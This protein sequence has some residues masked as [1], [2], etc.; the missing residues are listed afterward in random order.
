MKLWLLLCL[1]LTLRG[2]SCQPAGSGIRF[3]DHSYRKYVGTRGSKNHPWKN[4][5]DMFT[6]RGFHMVP[7]LGDVSA[8]PVSSIPTSLGPVQLSAA[9]P[10][11]LQDFA[12]EY[13]IP[14]I[15]PYCESTKKCLV[16]NQPKAPALKEAITVTLP[17][18]V[19]AVDMYIDAAIDCVT[20]LRALVSCKLT[21]QPGD[22]QVKVKVS[23][24]CS[25]ANVGK[26]VGFL[27]ETG[28]SIDSVTIRCK[29]T[30]PNAL[31]LMRVGKKVQKAV[32]V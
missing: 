7:V 17:P 26:Y 12:A 18:G 23:S 10:F 29:S 3:I 32:H 11:V 9:T 6:K 30:Y 8:E 24:V 15:W 4:G 25:E 21:V 22:V 2:G 5:F 14:T 27:D 20:T 16:Y 19:S 28:A 13:G 31:A 1:F